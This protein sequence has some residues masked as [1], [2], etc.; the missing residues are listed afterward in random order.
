MKRNIQFLVL[1]LILSACT[2]TEK[3]SITIS[4]LE[5]VTE[6]DFI[7]KPGANAIVDQ[8]G[9]ENDL[10][11]SVK[12]RYGRIS[13]L[14]HN[15]RVEYV[16]GGETALL[17]NE[18]TRRTDIKKFKADIKQSLE[19][20]RDSIGYP[21]SSIW[22]P[23]TAELKAL[24]QFPNSQTTLYLYSDLQENNSDWFSVHRDNDLILLERTP[25]KA[26]TLFLGKAEGIQKGKGNISVVVVYQ[27]RTMKE[28]GDFSRMSE[29]YRSIFRELDIP[30]AFTA[31]LN[32]K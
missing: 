6:N 3:E 9:L 27:P 11:Q 24:Q 5:D 18:I 23:L 29:L 16:L 32:T 31:Q 1:W 25:K 2:S 17:G 30:I 19:L 4:V 15:Q 21:Y 22:E 8:Y 28:D 7:A 14:I 26:R 12:F 10:W 13:N 20:S